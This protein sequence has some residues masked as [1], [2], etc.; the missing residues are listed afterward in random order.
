M[1]AIPQPECPTLA[2][3]K[4]AVEASQER[5]RRDYIGASAIGAPCARAIWYEYHQYPREPFAAETLW[6]FEDGHKSEAIM[7]E[8]L[9]LVPGIE[10]WTH[11]PDGTQY[12]RQAMGGKFKGHVDGVVRGL[13]QAPKRAHVWEH[14]CCGQ[15]KFDEF[16]TIKAKFG[17]KA[18]L[19]EW[20]MQ[21]FVQAQM[22][23][24]YLHLDRHY[25]TVALAG[26]RD[27]D[28]VRT[29]Y[30]PEVAERYIDRADGV[31]QAKEPPARVSEKADYFV[32]R[33]CNFREECHGKN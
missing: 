18:T 8:R 3:V 20:N 23:M 24:H 21:Y 33:W 30:Q 5:K 7:A 32:C 22:N 27:V 6:N 28:A 15:K 1:V 11:K 13:L 29:E 2:A 25:L 17:E 19:R 16:K 9:R 10:L 26:S 4:R 12:G 31:L 14:K